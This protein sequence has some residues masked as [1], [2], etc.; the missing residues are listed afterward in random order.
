MNARQLARVARLSSKIAAE[1]PQPWIT[2]AS[3]SSLGPQCCRHISTSAAALQEPAE[4]E[5]SPS[6]SAAA[7]PIDEQV[8]SS[9]CKL[10]ARHHRQNTELVLSLIRWSC[11]WLIS[12]QKKSW[13][14][15]TDTLL[16]RCGLHAEA[17]AD[18][19]LRSITLTLQADPLICHTHR[20]M[21]SGP[22][23]MP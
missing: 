7:L 22:W 12:P 2:T 1:A 14:C 19:A 20:Q 11:P 9:I 6:T 4:I 8:S 23:Q 15:W 5:V 16:V 21:P 3:L 13:R 18:V 10:Y 17:H